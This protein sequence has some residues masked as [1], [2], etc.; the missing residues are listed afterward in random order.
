[1]K[2]NRNK[3]I[4][5]YKIMSVEDGR[6]ATLYHGVGG[7]RFLPFNV[8]HK[9]E[10]KWAGEATTRYWTGFHVIPDFDN[11]VKYL[12][13]FT[14]KKPRVIVKCLAKNTIPKESSRKKVLL[15]D[16]MMLI[17]VIG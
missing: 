16:K 9:A 14:S 12:K 13:K 15:A 6:I 3:P 2:S 4:V 8:W 10:R 17:S 7:T 5:C 11:C 1:M